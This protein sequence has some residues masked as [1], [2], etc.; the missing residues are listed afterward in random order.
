[1]KKKLFIFVLSSILVMGSCFY[2]IAIHKYNIFPYQFFKYIYQEIYPP[3][4][5]SIGIYS[6]SSPFLMT[7]SKDIKNPV[8]TAKNVTDIEAEF[9]ADPFILVEKSK[10]YMFFEVLNRKNK[11]GD[12]GLAESVDGINWKYKQIVLDEQFHL[13]YPY[14]FKWNDSYYLIPESHEDVS[15]KIYKATDF[16]AKWKYIGDLLRGYHFVDPSII[17]YKNKWWLFVSVQE[18][19]VLNLYYSDDLMGQWKQHPQSPIVKNDKNISR[20]GGRLLLFDDKLY[21]FTQD[22]YPTYGNQVFAFEIT[23]IS[24]TSYRERI[25]SDLPIV[26]G[27]KTGW[28]A[29]GMHHVDPFYIGENKWLSAVDGYGK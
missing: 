28:N 14:V 15:V 2:G 10:Y 13:S 26:K 8:L 20:P 16:P 5:F 17:H 12:I 3:N 22:D 23:E 7:D 1:M 18:N 29:F 19:D 24:T 6:G 4:N 11:Q 9:V 21:R 27:S 25:V